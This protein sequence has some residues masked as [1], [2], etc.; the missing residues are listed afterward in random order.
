M[1]APTSYPS[2]IYNQTQPAQIIPNVAQ[3][4]A[5][6]APGTWTTTPYPLPSPTP[7]FDPGLQDTDIRL[8]QML[9]EL[10][11]LNL[12]TSVG[13]NNTEELSALRGEVLTLDSS[14]TS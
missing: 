4:N 2:W 11:V 14:L 6:P 1:A 13:F 10:R 5:L 12:M 9:I 8:Q 7:P 3:F